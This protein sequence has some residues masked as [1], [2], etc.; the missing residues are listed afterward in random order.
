MNCY[1]YYGES[2]P[3]KTWSYIIFINR[4]IN[5]INIVNLCNAEHFT[6]FTRDN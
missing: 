6:I 4:T 1:Y 5:Y 2:P 3:I